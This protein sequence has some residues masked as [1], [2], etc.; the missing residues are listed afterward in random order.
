MR[1]AGWGGNPE[2]VSLLINLGVE[3]E[4]KEPEFGY[5]ALACA[6]DEG[7]IQIIE[8]LVNA[9]CDIDHQDFEGLTALMSSIVS[10]QLESVQA[11]VRLGA[12]LNIRDKVGRTAEDIAAGLEHEAIINFFKQYEVG[13]K[14]HLTMG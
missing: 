9:G 1:A 10:N 3:L 6:A 12:N 4:L 7:N 2:L 5:T 13:G 14:G 11:L 8:V